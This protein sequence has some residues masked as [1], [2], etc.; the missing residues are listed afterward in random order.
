[1]HQ[2]EEAAVSFKHES[3]GDMDFGNNWIANLIANNPNLKS[4]KFDKVAITDYELL[5][6]SEMEHLSV[7]HFSGGRFSSSG[8]LTLLRGK[9][10]HLLSEV[11]LRASEDIVYEV[12][13][14]IQAITDERGVCYQMTERMETHGMRMTRFCIRK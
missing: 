10:R 7:V 13:G 4:L 8:I 2:L 3:G 9:S 1:M 6:M 11:S 14:E 12:E 5:L